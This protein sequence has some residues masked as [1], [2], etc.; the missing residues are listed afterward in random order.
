MRQEVRTNARRPGA[1]R[2]PRGAEREKCLGGKVRE[3]GELL[4][5][6]KK[7]AVTTSFLTGTT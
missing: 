3:K 5:L 6:E 7:G 2:A 1:G 4:S